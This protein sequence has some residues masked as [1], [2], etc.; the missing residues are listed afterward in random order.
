M[1]GKEA[2]IRWARAWWAG[3]DLGAKERLEPWRREDGVF[4]SLF[5]SLA[6]SVAGALVVFFFLYPGSEL[7]ACA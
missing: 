4:V 3:L 1:S 5:P 6:T 7:A 2:G